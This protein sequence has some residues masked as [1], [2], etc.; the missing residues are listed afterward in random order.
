MQP[1]GA[2]GSMIYI[3]VRISRWGGLYESEKRTV[4]EGWQVVDHALVTAAPTILK[5]RLC[6]VA[7]GWPNHDALSVLQVSVDA[8]LFQARDLAERRAG[9]AVEEVLTS[10]RL[11]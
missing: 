10:A 1:P 2:G 7:A 8:E 9:V 5:V 3:G 6:S 4:V 11:H